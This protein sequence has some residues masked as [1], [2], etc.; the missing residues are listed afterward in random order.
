MINYGPLVELIKDGDAT[1][2]KE[3]YKELDDLIK[4]Y[5]YKLLDLQQFN[6]SQNSLHL[7]RIR[8]IYLIVALPLM[9]N[10]FHRRRDWVG[11]LARRLVEVRKKVAVLLSRNKGSNPVGR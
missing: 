2:I 3:K 6:L 9:E 8:L 5:V 4:T 1:A 11:R 10:C 7:G